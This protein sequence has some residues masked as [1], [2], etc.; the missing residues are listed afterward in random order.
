MAD[1]FDVAQKAVSSE[2][3]V[4]NDGSARGT[5]AVARA[6]AHTNDSVKLAE[7]SMGQEKHKQALEEQKENL[8]KK[9]FDNTAG[10]INILN[11]SS[12]PVRK[13]LIPQMY[14]RAEEA[15]TPFAPGF[16][17]AQF[18]DENMRIENKRAMDIFM[19]KNLRENPK[20]V[21]EYLMTLTDPVKY[22]EGK[23]M[24]FDLQHKQDALSQADRKMQVDKSK[25]VKEE[26]TK[27]SER[28]GKDSIPEVMTAIK[29]TE[30]LL[31]SANKGEGIYSDKSLEGLEG[32]TGANAIKVFGLTVGEKGLTPAQ[33]D[34]K[35]SVATIRNAYLKLRSG[36]AV[37]DQEADR[38]FEELGAGLIRDPEQIKIGLQNVTRIMGQA[39]K[40]VEAG[41]S[42]EAKQLYTQRGGGLTS[43]TLPQPGAQKPSVAQD[44][45]KADQIA[46]KKFDPAKI[47]AFKKIRGL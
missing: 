44:S 36:G 46:K 14:K 21:E 30:K 35:Q 42:P 4:L 3:Q 19:S 24:L 32:L 47:E 38:F 2:Q 6:S 18:N 33:K 37:T 13:Q 7:M 25:E 23:K 8:N 15:G 20:A 10:M 34:I 17:E 45:A 39:V 5:A 22:E 16:L 11:R 9:K 31:Q 12:D 28:L 43:E 29:Q 27:L 41:Y 1:V 26:T 40:N